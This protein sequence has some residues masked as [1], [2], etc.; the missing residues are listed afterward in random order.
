M[1]NQIIQI[2]MQRDGMTK[3]EAKEL[4]DEAKEAV[5]NG[6]DPE[7]ILLEWFGLEPDYIF[8]LI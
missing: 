2:L 8:D 3:A 7:E 1:K 6:E 5:Y 4:V